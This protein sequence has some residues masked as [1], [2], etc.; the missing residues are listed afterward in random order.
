FLW[1]KDLSRPDWESLPLTLAGW[2]MGIPILTLLM[3]ASMF[4]QMWM[5][6]SAG[7]PNQRR[8]MLMMPVIFTAMFVTFPAGLTIYWL[9]NNVL[10]IAQQYL[11]NRMDQ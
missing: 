7:D 2:Q 5:T 3:G 1:I 11:I 9:V 10:S 6:P 4:V 8:M